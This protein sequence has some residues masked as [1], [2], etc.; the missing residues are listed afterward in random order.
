MAVIESQLKE[1]EM[2]DFKGSTK[3]LLTNIEASPELH[4]LRERRNAIIHVDP[5]NPAIT[6]D[7]QWRNRAKL[8]EE[9]REAVKLMFD[10]F[11][12]FPG[13]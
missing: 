6:L 9:A 3:K 2:S 1:T 4:K 13:T 7:Q 10:T 11:Y 5:E 8:E 12:M